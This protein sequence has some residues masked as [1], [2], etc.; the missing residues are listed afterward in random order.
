MSLSQGCSLP[1]SP[2][3]AL[4]ELS[5]GQQESSSTASSPSLSLS[6]QIN[7]NLTARLR[8]SN[9][10]HYVFNVTNPEGNVVALLQGESGVKNF[11]VREIRGPNGK[12]IPNGLGPSM[13]RAIGRAIQDRYPNVETVSGQRISGARKAAG[14]VGTN[15]DLVKVRLPTLRRNI[16]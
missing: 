5:S 7:Q 8:L 15:I 6:L 12:G 14:V 10:E 2:P 4:D 1:E 11:A 3:E 9:P 13:V 16:R